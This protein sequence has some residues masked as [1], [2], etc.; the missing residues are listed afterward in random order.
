MKE[1]YKQDP[2][3]KNAEFNIRCIR[4]SI[5]ITTLGQQFCSMIFSNEDE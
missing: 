3:F 1:T 5:K 4:G 2:F